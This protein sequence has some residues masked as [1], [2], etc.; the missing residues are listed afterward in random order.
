MLFGCDEEVTG[1]DLKDAVEKR[2]HLMA[3]KNNRV[4]DAFLI[5]ASGDA[6]GEECL[7]L[8][9][10]IE[11][12]LVP[13][14]EE[15]LDAEAIAGG[16]EAVV[17]FVPEDKGELATE[18]M[19]AMGAEFFVK[20]ESDFAVRPG[21]ETM[22][23][24]F[25]FALNALVVVELAVDDDVGALIFTGDGLVSCGEIDDAEAGVAEADALVG[26]D[27]LTL[28]VWAAVVEGGSCTLEYGR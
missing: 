6:G 18:L 3:T 15:R 12:L 4:E 2:A 24:R 19:E 14:V 26:A 1:W 22:A 5:P 8:G 9:G 27:P 28:A 23:A 17:G 20:M 21:A 16:E 7:D 25:E 11:R 10:E 13:G